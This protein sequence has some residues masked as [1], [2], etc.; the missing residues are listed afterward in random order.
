MFESVKIA[1]VEPA[2]MLERPGFISS[3][4]FLQGCNFRCPFCHNPELISSK[5]KITPFPYK[6]FLNI[7]NNK[8]HWVDSVIFTGGEPSL[9]PELPALIAKIKEMGFETGI[10]T[11]G[12]NPAM[13]KSLLKNN[14][15]DY[16]ALDVKNT[17]AKY[18]KT[19]GRKTQNLDPI[20]K[21]IE[22]TL[23]APQNVDTIFR[24][25]IVPGLIEPGDIRKI[26]QLIKGA[27]KA[28]LQQFRPIKCFNQEYE[29]ITPYDSQT[30]NKMADILKNYVK[31]VER[32]FT[33]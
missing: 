2:S 16:V 17:P 30:L 25:T 4:V 11:N 21:S 20:F 10:H 29:K 18:L 6:E 28:S 15:I 27:K 19:I 31:E 33:V 13:L 14:L 22:L 12:T 5:E 32:E 24:T 1:G 8:K 23:K 26:G 9:Y 3:I 7:L